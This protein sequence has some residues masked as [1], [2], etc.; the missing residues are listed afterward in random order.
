LESIVLLRREVIPATRATDT[1]T[2]SVAVAIASLALDP[3]ASK[4]IERYLE[5]SRAELLF[6]KGVVLVEGE[7]EQYLVPCLATMVNTPL[8]ENSLTVCSISGTHFE[9]YVT[10]VRSL[11]IPYVV[12]TDGDPNKKVTGLSRARSLLESTLPKAVVAALGNADLIAEAA[13]AHIFVG[14]KTLEVDL[15]AAGYKTEVTDTLEDLAPG[16]TARERAVAW[17]A[18][19]AILDSDRMLK[20]I[21][22][23]GKGRFAQALSARLLSLP[24]SRAIPAYIR[25]AL[26]SLVEAAHIA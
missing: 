6:S 17:R 16:K 21:V 3:T 2:R 26:A 12:I 9:S 23:I 8:E 15:I 25:D 13:R 1:Q 20:D 7:A 19:G 10:L 11:G 18:P 5:V 14:E 24:P 22:E 4:D